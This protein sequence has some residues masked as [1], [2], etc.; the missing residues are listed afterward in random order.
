LPAGFIVRQA[1]NLSQTFWRK[2]L[3]AD[4]HLDDLAEAH[5]R[6][7]LTCERHDVP[8]EEGNDTLVQYASRGHLVHQDPRT[9]G[10]GIDA[11]TLEGVESELEVPP[12]ALVL[13]QVEAWINVE[14]RATGRMSLDAHRQTT[15]AFDETR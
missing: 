13:I 7:P 8:L 5:E 15:F 4:H 14:P 11:S 12:P 6:R 2:V 1:H 3:L 10:L 9:S